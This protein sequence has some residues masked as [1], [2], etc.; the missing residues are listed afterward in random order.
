MKDLGEDKSPTHVTNNAVF[1]GSTAELQ[2]I[3]KQSQK[4]K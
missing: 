4:D 2:K 3:L 1:V